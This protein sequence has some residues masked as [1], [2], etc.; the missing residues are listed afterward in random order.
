MDKEFT[1]IYRTNKIQ[2]FFDKECFVI[3]F[4]FT[5]FYLLWCSIRKDF[6]FVVWL[7]HLWFLK[8]RIIIVFLPG[9]LFPILLFECPEKLKEITIIWVVNLQSF[10]ALTMLTSWPPRNECIFFKLKLRK[11]RIARVLLDVQL[12]LKSWLD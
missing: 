11:K 7:I 2:T 12:T 3:C 8:C 5:I 9:H 10:L 1:N 4:P 6:L